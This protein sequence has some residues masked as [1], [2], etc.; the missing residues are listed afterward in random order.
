MT[1]PG[2]PTVVV[3]GAMR[4]G[5]TTLHAYLDTHPDVHASPVKEPHHFAWP[6]GLPAGAGPG[7]RAF[8]EQVVVDRGRYRALWAGGPP[9]RHRLESSAMYLHVDGTARRLV[10]AVPDVHVV[11]LLRDPTRRAWSSFL[12]QRLRSREPLDDF[13][14]ALREEPDRLAAGWL[15]I[16]AYRDAGHYARQLAPWVEAVGDRLHVVFLE[17]L[18]ADPAA[19]LAPVV[20]ALGLD[21]DWGALPT[22]NRSGVPRHPRLQRVL[23]WRPPGAGRVLQ[24][25]PDPLVDTVRRLRDANVAPPPSPDPTVL[26]RL[27]AGYRADTARLEELLGRRVPDAWG[28]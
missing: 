3:A 18:Q 17:E 24:A 10:T 19:A 25:L 1:D 22:T 2:L 23:Q 6:D 5:T 27:R 21:G 16:W 20:A 9:T 4:C 13:D 11:V 26:A 12:Y 28:A 15:P 7:D 8:L 14:R